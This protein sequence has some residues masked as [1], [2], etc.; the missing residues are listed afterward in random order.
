MKKLLD[1]E[2][3]ILQALWGKEPQSMKEIIASVQEDR[4]D[5][6]WHYKTYHSYLRVMLEKELIACKVISAR[7][8]LYFAA[9]TE[10]QALE[11]ENESLLNRVSRDSIGRLVAM[12]AK[13]ISS[14]DKEELL[15][16]F[17]D[18]NNKGGET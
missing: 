7:D 18:L 6:T 5:I 17:K 4:P 11:T 12:M 15:Q 16:L 8:K 9:I 2:W 14:E 13:E 10:Q 1:C 3:V